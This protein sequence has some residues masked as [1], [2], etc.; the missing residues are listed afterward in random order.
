MKCWRIW[1]ITFLCCG[2]VLLPTAEARTARYRAMWRTDP[3][4]TMVIGW[5]QISGSAP[6]LHYDEID[7]GMNTERYRQQ[8]KP[9]LF[10]P[11]K[12]MNNHFV[13]LQNLKPNTVYYFVLT[14][15]EGSSRRMSFRTAPN[16]INDR[17]SIIAGGDSRNY[18]DARISANKLVSRLRPHAVIFD[19]DMT[20]GDTAQEWREWLDDWQ[21]TIG[22]DGRLFPVIVAR[23]NHE[24]TNRSLV[25]I[26]DIPNPEGYYSLTFGDQLLRVI[27]LNSMIAISGDQ[28]DWLEQE[29]RS[30]SQIH[31]TFAQY[32]HSIRPHTS[33]KPERDDQYLH[34]ASLFYK[35]G[36]D[37][38]IESDAH[39][40]KWTY[41]IRPSTESG[42]DEGFVRDDERGTVYIGEGC[43][44]APL[45][46]NDDDK[47]WTRNSGSFN[48]FNLIF[49]GSDRL[50]IRTVLTDHSVGVAEVNDS[51]PFSLPQGLRIW[52]P[53]QGSVV[54]MTSRRISAAPA[55]RPE[56]SFNFQEAKPSEAQIAENDQAWAKL[57]ALT[58]STA[59]LVVVPGNLEQSADILLQCFDL[60]K[61]EVVKVPLG[62]QPAGRHS[63]N[64]NMRQ[65]PPGRYLVVVRS[66]IKGLAYYQVIKP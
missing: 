62:N 66:G 8:R 54:Q 58:C 13:R 60:Q 34:W 50:E 65:L 38:A 53:S 9:D 1:I 18:R 30:S 21:S 44:G 16:T 46:A 4:T 28:K 23:G 5:D 33:L 27:T 47:S 51:N 43:W 10:I 14:D 36:L 15:S 59:G 49:V 22:S 63:W 40:T 19:G 17:L 2:E 11:G 29:L 12:G 56:P 55:T 7:H 45:R 41:P 3:A 61:R 31:W 39:V 32:H 37:L 6:T 57:P 52:E 26:F 24:A 48:Q 25:E 42:N 64:L 35:Y 20:G